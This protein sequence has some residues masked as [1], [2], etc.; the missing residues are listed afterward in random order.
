MNNLKR[1][2]IAVSELIGLI[3]LAAGLAHPQE[4]GEGSSFE[5]TL[6]PTLQYRSVDGD[7]DKFREDQWVQEGWAGGVDHFLL[8]T[9][10]EGDWN[11]HMEGRAIMV[12][13]GVTAQSCVVLSDAKI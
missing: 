12:L 2:G 5:F 11:L 1:K 10:M 4:S 9:P 6:N 13:R 8:K 3:L 7:G